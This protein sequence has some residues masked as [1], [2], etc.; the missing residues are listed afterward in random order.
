M[1]I[2]ETL[3]P[4]IFPFI[5]FFGFLFVGVQLLFFPPKKI[6]SLYGYRTPRSM[7]NQE[8]WDF[9]QKMAARTMI[10][11]AFIFLFVQ[12]VLTYILDHYLHWFEEIIP[13][14]VALLIIS[15]FPL[16]LYCEARLIRFENQKS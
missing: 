10:I 14:Q 15:I 12:S 2:I 3:I 8:N 1:N 7:K 6:D 4:G 9:A 11:F 16:L 5:C 13:F